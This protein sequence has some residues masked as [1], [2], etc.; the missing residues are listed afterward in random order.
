[1]IIFDL[2]LKFL[3]ADKDNYLYRVKY[4]EF[5]LYPNVLCVNVSNHFVNYQVLHKRVTF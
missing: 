4:L 1:M 2:F 5:V 3:L